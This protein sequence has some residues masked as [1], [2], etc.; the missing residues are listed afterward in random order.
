[1]QKSDDYYLEKVKFQNKWS[2]KIFDVYKE[3][4]KQTPV[5]FGLNDKIKIWS[6]I[7][8]ESKKEFTIYKNSIMNIE[9]L[10]KYNN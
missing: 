7:V 4:I 5:D 2:A 10:K 6:E 3:M 8:A 1:M 9:I